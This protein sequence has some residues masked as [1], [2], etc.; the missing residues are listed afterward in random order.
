MKNLRIPRSDLSLCMA[1]VYI[2]FSNR[3]NKFYIGSCKDLSE[4]LT[5]HVNKMFVSSFTAEADDWELYFAIADLGYQQA[6]LIE[7]HI[8]RMKSA[9]YIMDLV[10]YPQI[11][12]KLKERYS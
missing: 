8:K 1:I 4:R 2:L 3:L 12:E 9:K 7:L 6:R 11:I 10:K 5:Q